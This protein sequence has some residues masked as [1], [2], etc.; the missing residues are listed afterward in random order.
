[1]AGKLFSI[2]RVKN[3]LVG[4][5]GFMLVAGLLLVACGDN[6]V[7]P[8][9]PT[10][11]VQ[12]T[13]T[14]QAT[15]TPAASPTLAGPVI[16]IPP[17]TVTPLGNQQ[18]PADPTP[19]SGPIATAPSSEP[20]NPT[21]T[22]GPVQNTPAP[23]S[24]N[25][26]ATVVN[27]SPVSQATPVKSGPA[28]K[29]SSVIFYLK[30][31]SLW[32]A[33]PG[34]KAPRQVAQRV[35]S[36]TGA[37]EGRAVFLQQNS[38]G[39]NRFVQLKLVTLA[40]G[41]LQ[42]SLLD[43]RLFETL[44]ADRQNEYPAGLYGV[45]TRAMA[46]LAISPDNSQVA[47]I[48]ADLTGPTFDGM[49]DGEK[50][51]ELWLANLDPKNPQP[52]RLV[53]SAKDYIA[54]PLWSSDNSRIA[55]IRTTGFGTGAGY[56]TALWSVYK[57]GSR[58][59]FLTGPDLGT[60]QGKPFSA[61]P[62]YNLRWVGP[63]TLGFQAFNQVQSPIFLHDLSQGKDFPTALVPNA[64]SDAV[65]CAQAQR[66]VYIKQNPGGEPQPGSYSISTV[67]PAN[68]PGLVD[69]NAIE[70]YGCE[71]SSL[72]YRTNQGQVVLAQIN[73]DGAISAARS[74]KFDNNQK[75]DGEAKLAPGGKL[76][77]VRDGKTTRLLSVN[78][79][80]TELKTGPVKYETLILEWASENM[81]VG[82]AFTPG[83]TGQL[84]AANV[85][86][87][88]AFK[89]LDAGSIFSFAGPGQTGKGN[90]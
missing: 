58:L 11:T 86:E 28:S 18:T 77:V 50:P 65:F 5:V 62:A 87:E 44:P 15:A 47:Y 38:T 7:T 17:G 64:G 10:A 52:H 83:Q 48:K 68:G 54:Q 76:A 9:P 73:T 74:V 80:V 90:L 12:P 46:D 27:S 41:Q 34:E 84:L 25:P 13:V 20:S 35:Y 6:T 40:G 2:R 59:A 4:L 37:G 61:S 57:D 89:S 51:T 63:L 49:F 53:P 60:V 81:L 26:Q 56:S 42:E 31:G 14:P 19:T 66:Y 30:D 82:V 21:G 16:A 22:P 85:A 75:G 71:G 43:T 23:T 79:Q 1:M 33:V 67:N 36:Y 8:T 24:Q 70:L 32:A 3:K 39:P 45:D 72:L 29:G 78:G 69:A 88:Q 55:F